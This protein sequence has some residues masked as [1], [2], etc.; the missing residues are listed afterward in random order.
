[1]RKSVVV[2]VLAALTAC[3]KAEQPGEQ[4]DTPA[5]PTA[6]QEMAG[7]NVSVTAVPGV[8]LT[9]SYYFRLPVAAVAK[10]QEQHASECEKLAPRCRITGM[11]YHAGRNRTISA[12]LNVKLAPEIARQFGKQSIAATVANGGMLT[13]SEIDSTDAGSVVAAA[14]RAAESASDE[15]TKITAQ[16]TQPGLPSAERTTLQQRLMQLRDTRRAAASSRA[17]AALLLGS[18]PMTLHYASGV[19]DLGYSDGPI[20]GAIKDGWANIV[21]GS[22]VIV[23]L[24]ITLLPWLAAAIILIFGIRFVRRWLGAQD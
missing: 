18:T 3:S 12:T 5:A 17:D 2:M 6:A 16:L 7:P 19:I 9:Y 10:T 24:A 23:M 1:M 22:A 13:D 4:Q 11:E 20:L 21:S 8:A 14:D 15:E